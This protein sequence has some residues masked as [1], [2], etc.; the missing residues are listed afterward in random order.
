MQG[1]VLAAALLDLTRLPLVACFEP[2]H[3]T[4]L[5]GM[6]RRSSGWIGVIISLLLRTAAP[7]AARDAG[8]GHGWRNGC[9]GEHRC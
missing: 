7:G 6:D 3:F 9:S 2:L 1:E 5:S 4:G 8:P